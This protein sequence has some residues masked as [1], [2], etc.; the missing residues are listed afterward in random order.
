MGRAACPATGE[1]EA[2][3]R[4]MRGLATGELRIWDGLRVT[5]R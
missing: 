3:A 1:H 2:D 4:P 5:R